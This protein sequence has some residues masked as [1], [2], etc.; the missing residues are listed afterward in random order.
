LD[1]GGVEYG[2]HVKDD[3]RLDP[4]GIRCRTLICGGGS[5]QIRVRESAMV[6]SSICIRGDL[7]GSTQ[8]QGVALAAVSDMVASNWFC[9]R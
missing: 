8:D 2:G 6:L 1:G 5:S 4:R 7:A 3:E 9:A